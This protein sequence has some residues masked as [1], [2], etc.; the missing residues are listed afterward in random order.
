M[1]DKLP[2]IEVDD[3]CP[4]CKDEG[5]YVCART[6]HMRFCDCG[7]AVDLMDGMV[8]RRENFHGDYDVDDRAGDDYR[9]NDAGEWNWM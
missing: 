1:S 5:E 3:V 2:K 7:A 6:N 9:Q 8:A 4:Q